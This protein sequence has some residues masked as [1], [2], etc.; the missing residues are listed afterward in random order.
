[1]FEN[2]LKSG[3]KIV[4]QPQNSV[5]SAASVIMVMIIASRVLGLIR[6]MVLLEFFP[7]EQISLFFAAFRLPDTIFEILVFGTFSAAFI[8]VFAKSIQKDKKEAWEV[9]ASVANIG[10]IT[11][12][13][14]GFLVG[15]FANELYSVFAPGYT[16]PERMQIV[17]ITR[18]LLAAQMFFVLSY[19][20]TGVLESMKR[21][22]IPAVAPLFYNL[23]IIISTIFFWDSLGLMAPAYGVLVGSAAH[24]FV[25]LPLAVKLG[26]RFRARISLSKDV[27]QIGRLAAPRVLE[28]SFLQA[29]KMVELFL[30]SLISTASYAYF[31]LANSLQLLPIG[32]F[33]TSIAK[34]AF[35]TLSAE[36]DDRNKFAKTFW[37]SLYLMVFL[38]VPLAVTMIVL[39]IPIVRLVYGRELFDWQSTVQTSQVLSAFGVGIVFQAS[40]SLLSRG[41]YAM[42][43]TRT[44]VT[45]S[46]MGMLITIAGNFYFIRYLGTDVWGLA[47][48]FSMGAIFQAVLLFYLI[49]RKL[50]TFNF[51]K[52]IPFIK[53][54]ISAFFSGGV[55]F[56]LIKVFDQSVWVKRLSFLSELDATRNLPFERFVLDTTFTINLLILTVS[57]SI[58][59]LLVYIIIAIL[60]RT[61]EVW[62]VY[63]MIK[64]TIKKGRDVKLPETTEVLSEEISET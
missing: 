62:V 57:V 18:V 56:L 24:F 41:F 11:F 20:M 22:L 33:G 5:F 52:L 48:A 63:R 31:Y 27:R 32:L 50:G 61:E 53:Y 8:P 30:A 29:S 7:S 45:I 4:S 46:I 23:G 17:E 44:P 64:R 21:F 54:S 42:H 40:I 19:V 6:S 13:V 3:K 26:F 14:F 25:Q 51:Q 43:D 59:G 16:I 15:V 47:A 35:P 60:L 36:S 55:M 37:G 34:A 1:M 39:R 9:A 38:I 58:I 10:I 12:S 2:I 49:N 28:I